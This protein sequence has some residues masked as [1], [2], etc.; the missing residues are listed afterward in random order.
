LEGD[1]ARI[2][3]SIVNFQNAARSYRG[4]GVHSV[5]FWFAQR[6][7]QLRLAILYKSI[8]SARVSALKEKV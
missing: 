7:R 4:R 6:L 2:F 5:W 8:W 3:G 1:Q